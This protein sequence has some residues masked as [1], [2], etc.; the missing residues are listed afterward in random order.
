M[1]VDGAAPERRIGELVGLRRRPTVVRFEHLESDQRDWIR[2]SF[3][4]TATVERHLEA[5]RLQVRAGQ[6]GGSFVIGSYGSGKSHLLAYLAQTAG[7]WS[8]PAPHVVPVSLLNYRGSRTLEEILVAAFALDRRVDEPL[9]RRETWERLVAPHRGGVLLLLDELSEFLRSKPDSGAFNEDVRFLQFLGEWGAGAKLWTI[10]SLQ[11]QIEHTGEL[12][13]ALYRKIKD[14]YPLRLLL[15]PTHVEDLV[16]EAILVKREGYDD[17]VARLLLDLEARGVGRGGVE[18]DRLALSR[19]YPLHPATLELLDE[20]RDRFSQARGIVDFVT[21]QLGG[22]EARG[23]APFLDQPW[24]ALLTP[25]RIVD[26]FEDLLRVQPEFLDI[27]Q[28]VLPYWEKRLP[29]LFQPEAQRAL[30]RRLVS[31]LVLVHLSAAREE[32]SAR[33]A[34]SWLVLGASRLDPERDVKVIAGVLDRMAQEGRFVRQRGGRYRLELEDAGGALFERLFERELK[35]LAERGDELFEELVA[36]LARGEGF[37]PFELERGSWQQRAVR[38]H[39]HDRQVRVALADDPPGEVSGSAELSVLLRVPWGEQRPEP[40]RFTF[41]PAR[42][43]PSPAHRELAALERLRSR[44]WNPETAQRLE[45]RLEERRTLLRSQIEQAYRDGRLFDERAESM[46]PPRLPERLTLGTFVDAVAIACLQRVYPGFERTAPSYGPLS[47]EHRRRYLRHA[48]GEHPEAVLD[49]EAVRLVHEAYLAP[50]G[51]VTRAGR[52]HRLSARLDRNA[53]VR[54]V[55]PLLQRE[56]TPDAVFEHLSAP[57]H[58]LVADQAALLLV[59]LVIAGEIDLLLEGRSIRD[60][61]ESV[62]DPLAYERIVPGAHLS[63]ESLRAFEELRRGLGLPAVKEWTAIAQR[64]S[65]R[66]LC[67]RAAERVGELTR[68]RQRLETI[69]A[70]GSLIERIEGVVE[71]WRLLVPDEDAGEARGDVLR[72]VERFLERASPVEELVRRDRE[73]DQLPER[74]ERLGRELARVR[75]LLA[76]LRSMEDLAPAVALRLEALGEAPSLSRPEDVAAW[77]ERAREAYQQH[78]VGYRRAH[79]EFWRGYDQHPAR[80]W[81]APKVAGSRH[82]G[83]A[84]RV[85]RLAAVRR[86]AEEARCRGLVDLDFQ[87]HC[88]CG[89]DGREAPALERLE[90]LAEE[91]A[92]IEEAVSGFFDSAEV[93]ERV[94]SFI[95]EGFADREPLASY[96]LGEQSYPESIERLDLL[97]RHL[98]GIE[99]VKSLP[100]EPLIERIGGRVFE[101]GELLAEIREHLASAAGPGA[102]VRVEPTAGAPGRRSLESLAR[103]CLER[104]LRDGVAPPAGAIDLELAGEPEAEWISDAALRRLGGMGLPPATVRSVL[105][106]VAEGGV[107]PPPEAGG[108]VRAAAE[109]RSPREPGS[110][111][112]LG[113]LARLLYTHHAALHEVAGERWLARL[114]LLARGAAAISPPPLGERLASRLDAH[115][116]VLDALGVPLLPVF[117]EELDQLLPDWSVEAL[118]AASVAAPTTTRGWLQHLAAAGINHPYLKVDA[119]DRLLHESSLPFDDLERVAIATLRAELRP[120]LASL[121]SADRLV[122]FADHG[123]RLDPQG[124]RWVHGGDSALERLVPIIDLERG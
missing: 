108:L 101:I 77:L 33:E 5:L 115:W 121:K 56:T 45:R 64:A 1:M 111:E 34:A 69:E 87:A 113:A 97:D 54:S 62:P 17:A 114:D 93:R 122:V 38:W 63:A 46:I 112:E 3:H 24:G 42:L 29:E 19:L 73:L 86:A 82:L 89:F 59:V 6:G 105:R 116:L 102:R 2:E 36:D 67:E 103:W 7:A 44:P 22:D 20:V 85:D 51:L 120:H 12:E 80:R 119:I 11:E 61:Y 18:I 109:V 52:G 27:A 90:R 99:L 55:A 23:V 76:Q 25:E 28:Q 32:V 79:E 31:L 35:E 68:L 104:A 26:H 14:R 48:L 47:R 98:A 40:G 65:G 123:F 4:R 84:D 110:V 72:L 117:L 83:L 39:F 37:E 30:A 74:I 91:Q 41:V 95:G 124:R 58:G 100:L 10:A 16:A 92:A 75:H 50:M 9:D 15:T 53:L 78:A 60:L 118:V 43:E 8:D 57:I 21:T 13:H 70:G 49:D 88:T 81:R 94:E 96:L 66:E 107:E 106:L 71:L